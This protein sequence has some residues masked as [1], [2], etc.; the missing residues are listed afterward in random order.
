MRSLFDIDHGMDYIESM[1][2]DYGEVVKIK[3]LFGSDSIWLSDPR[4]LEH[5]LLKNPAAW[6]ANWLFTGLMQLLF[7]PGLFATAGEQ[8]RR[9]RRL[10]NPMFSGSHVSDLTP[11]FN[12]I[13]QQLN[14]K[15]SEDIGNARK[16]ETDL[17]KWMGRTTMEFI[18]QGGLG[19][20]FQSF[21]DQ[22]NHY[23]DAQIMLMPT[24]ARS[25]SLEEIGPMLSWIGPAWLRRL[26]VEFTP[27][28]AVQ[29]LKRIV[30]VLQKT[31]ESV[32]KERRQLLQNGDSTV[33]EE[34]GGKDILTLMLR[35]NE[36]AAPEDKLPN[37]ELVAQLS[38]VVFAGNDTISGA[39]CRMFQ[40]LSLNPD[41]QAR[42]REELERAN[43]DS[44]L[45]YSQLMDLPLLDAVVKETLRISA[46][47][48]TITRKSLVDDILPLWQP[49]QTKDGRMIT[50]IPCPKG[51]VIWVGISTANTSKNIWGQDAREWKP[52]RW[53][54]SDPV[55]KAKLPGV[56]ASMMT[57]MGGERGCIGYRMAILELKIVA[58]TLI[59]SF[60]FD[61][62]SETIKWHLGATLAPFVKGKDGKA[63]YG[64]TM[65]IIIERLGGELLPELYVASQ[66]KSRPQPS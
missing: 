45:G 11:M 64:P 55:A 38:T 12:N 42:L 50:E 37:E 15:I 44:G 52:D 19:Y 26:V 66:E 24:L 30:D 36:K 56:F 21:D 41:I 4:A 20:N 49:I 58:A 65:P 17:L 22:A 5:I 43:S 13:A 34:T 14:G 54:T 40:L 53:L 62:S 23:R 2:D 18:G 27:N 7:G 29:D 39:L 8:H 25:G 57:F 35:F 60:R 51:T 47:V 16:K 59:P 6:D 46:P 9:Q 61:P 10:L 3:G 31:S 1:A 28:K 32:V 48:T 63:D 33:M